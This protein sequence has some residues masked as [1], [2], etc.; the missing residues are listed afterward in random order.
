M[1]WGKV[2]GSALVGALLGIGSTLYLFNA[3][4]ARVEALLEKREPVGKLPA[5]AGASWGPE[6]SPSRQPGT[7]TLWEEDFSGNALRWPVN[8]EPDDKRSIEGGLYRFRTS[9]KDLYTYWSH[10]PA[11][12]LPVDIDICLGAIW[13]G[14]D[15]DR[16]FGLSIMADKDNRLLFGVTQ[17]GHATVVL[18]REGKRD[19]PVQATGFARPPG[20]S[21]EL[22]ALRRGRQVTFLVDD[23]EAGR[24][25]ANS[26]AWT[27]LG[28]AVVGDQ[29]VDFDGLTVRGR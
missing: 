25:E 19:Y 5:P 28:V 17:N 8:D 7:R 2:L 6:S 1:D 11:P 14:G 22:C 4:L 24:L 18:E 12:T 23:S 20:T 9:G 16:L 15:R 26:F 21:I 3:R 29:S 10:Q 27:R 13:R